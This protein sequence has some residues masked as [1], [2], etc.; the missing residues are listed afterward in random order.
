MR[1]QIARSEVDA[2]DIDEL[3]GIIEYAVEQY[4][5]VEEDD[6]HHGGCATFDYWIDGITVS[7]S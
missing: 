7:I 4:R 3:A 6:V 5:R 2:L 1:V